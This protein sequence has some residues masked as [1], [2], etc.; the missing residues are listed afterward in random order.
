MIMS[1][2]EVRKL[3]PRLQVIC[4]L[5]IAELGLT[6]ISDLKGREGVHS[7]GQ[8]VARSPK[9]QQYLLGLLLQL[10]SMCCTASPMKGAANPSFLKPGSFSNGP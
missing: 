4:S 5:R 6:Y 8:H 2:L 1:I 10:G 7:Q 9:G 3:K